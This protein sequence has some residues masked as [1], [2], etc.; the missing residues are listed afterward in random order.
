MI[1]SDQHRYREMSGFTVSQKFMSTIKNPHSWF[2]T[3]FIILIAFIYNAWPWREWSSIFGIW[4]LGTTFAWLENLAV[5]EFKYHVIGTLYLLPIFYTTLIFGWWGALFTWLIC[6]F[7][8]LPIILNLW[9]N[10]PLV[11]ANMAFLLIPFSILVI[12]A[13]LLEWRKREH[14]TLL[15]RENE[16]RLYL[17]N[18]LDELEI[19]RRHLSQD[20]HDDTIQTLL[21]I[22]NRIEKFISSGN[23]NKNEELEDTAL[24]IH[25]TIVNTVEN[26]RRICL[27]L[28]PSILDD[29]GLIPALRWLVD[30]TN[31]QCKTHIK[32]NIIG[33]ELKLSHQIEDNIFRIVQ[34]ALS[35]VRR[36]SDAN[37]ALVTLNF[38]EKQLQCL[39][40]DDGK[41]FILHNRPALFNSKGNLGLIGMY[42]RVNLLDGTI[43][44]Q[45]HPG[46]GTKIS[47]SV[48]C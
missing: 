5:I 12:I 40:E 21:T 34:S 48:K 17:S 8:L 6:I 11:L 4:Q 20:L 29:L 30:L 26:I 1:Y 37:N 47:I 25:N 42:E 36:H 16:R 24:W 3:L 10:L 9:P 44:I 45:S 33:E 46:D 2:V 18:M 23:L 27:N 28:R 19:A 41:G 14:K 7:L 35:N 31:Q 15:E 43:Q 32:I 13:I 38:R 22:N 39:I